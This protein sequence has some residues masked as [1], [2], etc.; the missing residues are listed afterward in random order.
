LSISLGHAERFAKSQPRGLIRIP[1]TIRS[2][3]FAASLLAAF[4]TT[5]CQHATLAAPPPDL[6]PSDANAKSFFPGYLGLEALEQRARKLLDPATLE[7]SQVDVVE[8]GLYLVKV[9]LPTQMH[10]VQL[11]D[12]AQFLQQLD[13]SVNGCPVDSLI[14]STRQF[15]QGGCVQVVVGFLNRFDQDLSLTGDADTAKR[16]LLQQ[17]AAF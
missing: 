7:T 8:V 17:R 13:S 1:S 10:E 14:T 2:A 15:Q 5:R 11:I 16:E 9:F 12:Q 4:H 6:Q 3:A